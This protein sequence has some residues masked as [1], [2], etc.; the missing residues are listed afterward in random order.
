MMLQMVRNHERVVSYNPWLMMAWPCSQEIHHISEPKSVKD[1]CSKYIAKE[2]ETSNAGCNFQEE[3]LTRVENC[4]DAIKT[5]Q[6]LV[7]LSTQH[8]DY[9]LA[10]V[11]LHIN[12]V[13]AMKFSREFVMVNVIAHLVF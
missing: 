4:S 8:H 13:P 7:R 1:Y 9:S 5:L 2:Q 12:N 6:S 11:H 3:V 10:E